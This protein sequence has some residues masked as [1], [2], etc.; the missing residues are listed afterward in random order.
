MTNEGF[1]DRFE[2]GFGK[3][4]I[5]YRWLIIIATILVV[6]GAGSGVRFLT[7]NNDTR[8]FFSEQNPQLHALEDLEGRR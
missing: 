6:L 3:W 4:V 5:K 1:I 2:T 8:A 7:F